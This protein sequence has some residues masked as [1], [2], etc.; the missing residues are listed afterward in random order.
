MFDVYTH[1]PIYLSTE[2]DDFLVCGWGISQIAISCSIKTLPSGY[3][4]P[5]CTEPCRFKQLCCQTAAMPLSV[6]I[7]NM[8]YGTV[9]AANKLPEQAVNLFP[10]SALSTERSYEEARAFGS[11]H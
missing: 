7:L 9:L 2:C 8:N 1:L 5:F 6:V 4:Q 10:Q 3:I 11:S